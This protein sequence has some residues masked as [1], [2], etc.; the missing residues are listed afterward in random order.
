MRSILEQFAYGNISPEPQ[1]FRHES[2]YK[3]EMGAIAEEKLNALL[4][5]KE[6][7]AFQKFVEAQLEVN[8]LTAMENL[9]YGFKLGLLMTAEAFITSDD[10]IFGAGDK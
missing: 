9:I 3:K 2:E 8:R 6:K 4:E 5:G 1:V 7:E 10:L